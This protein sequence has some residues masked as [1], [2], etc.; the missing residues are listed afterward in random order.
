MGAHSVLQ[1]Y[2]R[3]SLVISPTST[4]GSH[5][6]LLDKT[7][8]VYPKQQQREIHMHSEFRMRRSTMLIFSAARNRGNRSQEL[9]EKTTVIKFLSTTYP[10]KQQLLASTI[11]QRRT[12]PSLSNS[13][14]I[15]LQ[16]LWILCVVLILS[17]PTVESR[18]ENRQQQQRDMPNNTARNTP[19]HV[20]PQASAE[21]PDKVCIIGSGNWGSAIAQIVGRNAE[22]LEFCETEVSMWVYEEMIDGEKLT[23]I[24]N[25][26]HENVKYLPGVRLP[27]NVRAFPDL[28]EACE[29]ATLLIFVLPHQFLP[30]LLPTIRNAV[31]PS[32]RGVSL[33]KGLDF[34]KS[35][36]R[37]TLISEGISKEMWQEFRCGVLM[38]ANVANEVASGQMCESTLASRFGPP[39]DERTR[40]IF[41]SESFKVSHIEDIAGA[42][43]CGAL[44]N[45]IALGAG[46]VDG[47]GL[48]GNTKAALLRVGLKEMAQ[49]CRT[50]FEGIQDD[51]FMQ[52]AGMADLITTCYGGRNRKCAEAFAK[53][54]LKAEKLDNEEIVDL[55]SLWNDI[56]ASLLNGQKLQG[57]LAAKEAFTALDAIGKI[58]K[59]PLIKTIHEISFEGRKVS[60]ICDGIRTVSFSHL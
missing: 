48:G 18:E 57:T 3:T 52:S 46:F 36:N 49:F 6:S 32:C 28:S 31:H 39:L 10:D 59:F 21:L 42:E 22:K 51:T 14:F 29:G 20:N 56:E 55:E 54:R 25:T 35:R 38:G 5:F 53:R 50:F 47:L 7:Y 23:D 37:P 41:D 8:F 44:K 4:Y 34:D 16:R 17:P 9:R 24:I 58:D 40:Q 12:K 26:R 11:H 60:S 43:A 30:R 19:F 27:E 33:I 2:V 1:L 45:V 13:S 15:S